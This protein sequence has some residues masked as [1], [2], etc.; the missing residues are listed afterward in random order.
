MQLNSLKDPRIVEQFAVRIGAPHIRHEL[1]LTDNL[2]AQP[3]AEAFAASPVKVVGASIVFC[4]AGSMT[5]RVNLSDHT[6]TAG[7]ALV[8]LP[9]SIMQIREADASSRFESLSFSAGY[10]EAFASADRHM[11]EN[12]VVTLP[13]A[14]FEECSHLYTMLRR[15]LEREGGEEA[16]PVAKGYMQ[17][18]CSIISRH[19]IG[20]QPDTAPLSR[21]RELYL[22]Y[23]DLVREDYRKERSVKH[24]AGRLCVSPKYLSKTVKAESG[25]NASDFIDELTVFE[26]KALLADRRHSV[27]QVSEELH[28]PN[29]S[30]FARYFRLHT[31][32][33]PSSYSK[34]KT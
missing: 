6:V 1:V 10:F 11:R 33:S 34:R 12:P 30:F 7:E 29:A 14:D 22:R 4:L 28:F 31:G 16:R 19:W 23:L 32:I 2:S 20:R 9:A 17:A 18:L 8:I 13:E 24:Y 27:S 25:R 15:H 26:A 5:Y 21:P 3:E